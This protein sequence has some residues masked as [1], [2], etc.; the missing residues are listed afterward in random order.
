MMMK[1][2]L[3]VGKAILSD[4][5]YKVETFGRPF[6]ALAHFAAQPDFFDLVI[7]DMTMPGMTGDKLAREIMAIRPDMPVILCAGFSS[8]I[9]NE[10]ARAV[11]IKAYITKPVTRQTFARTIRNVLDGVEQ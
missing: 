1:M 7:T 2:V 3:E 8:P 6:A 9:N 10:S 5:G 4:L 11:G